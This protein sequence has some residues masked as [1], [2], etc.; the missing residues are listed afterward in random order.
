MIFNRLLLRR[1]SEKDEE[2][3]VGRS[4]LLTKETVS[5][6]LSISV[7]SVSSNHMDVA[8]SRNIHPHAQESFGWQSWEG[9]ETPQEQAANMGGVWPCSGRK[10]VSAL[11][12]AAGGQTAP[13]HSLQ[14]PENR[15]SLHPVLLR[16]RLT[17]CCTPAV[18]LEPVWCQGLRGLVTYGFLLAV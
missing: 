5:S 11:P 16:L 15:S 17:L 13:R 18:S 8:W 2:R 4:A 14:R 7:G 9:F 12:R 10:D 6:S 3:R 1:N